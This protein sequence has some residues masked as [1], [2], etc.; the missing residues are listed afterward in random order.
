MPVDTFDDTT[1]AV[2]TNLTDVGNGRRMVQLY[3]D[4]LRFCP[5]LGKWL[6]W[7]GRRWVADETDRIA[8][9]AKKTV[10]QMYVDAAR[11]QRDGEREALVKHALASESVHRLK[12]MIEAARSE[13]G[14]PLVV[15]ALDADEWLLNCENGMVDLRTGQLRDHQREDLCSKM[16]TA[17]YVQGATHPA[18]DKLLADST[19][20]DADLQTFLQRAA[21]YSICGATSEEVLLFVSGPA[22]TGKSTFIEAIRAALGD[23]AITADF[24][25]FIEQRGGGVR[26]DIARL[27]GARL[28]TSVEVSDGQTMAA[29]L[30]KQL[31]GGDRIAA[32]FLYRESFEFTPRFKLWLV[33]NHTPRV[34]DRDDAMWRR[35]VRI[36]FQHVIPVENR[37]PGLKET[38]K[39]DPDAKAAVLSWLV[40]G[41]LAWQRLRLQVPDVVTAATA[42]YREEMDPLRDF[43]ADC[44][45][46][47]GGYRTEAAR[48]RQ[49]YVRYCEENAVRRVLS[50]RDFAERLR[51][52]GC[53]QDRGAGGQRYWDGICVFDGENG[54][55]D[56]S[57]VT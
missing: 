57:D 9:I 37:D 20:G 28:V 47:G 4:D 49:R 29:G 39:H 22:A 48:V 5:A 26:N 55:S 30:V 21:G 36:P 43:F 56:T 50:P 6:L 16:A 14:I 31:T 27:H 17:R 38:L 15:D 33:A 11:L 32:R 3:G 24:S 41:C 10:Q 2:T 35:I 44:C 53:T 45:Q 7:D 42:A 12:A 23:Y 8:L 18:W 46:L 40:T 25:T 19:D 34:D 54:V 52:H 1:L 13:P 51:D